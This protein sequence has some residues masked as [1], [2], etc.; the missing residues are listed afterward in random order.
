MNAVEPRPIYR[1]IVVQRKAQVDHIDVEKLRRLR[2]QM[3]AGQ[4]I[5]PDLQHLVVKDTLKKSV[6][7]AMAWSGHGDVEVQSS[8]TGLSPGAVFA[9]ADSREQRGDKDAGAIEY[10]RQEG[11]VVSTIIKDH[12]PGDPEGVYVPSNASYLF[13]PGFDSKPDAQGQYMRCAQELHAKFQAFS[14]NKFLLMAPELRAGLT[15]ITLV[16]TP[17][18]AVPRI[19]VGVELLME[20][21]QKTRFGHIDTDDFEV[22]SEI[23]EYPVQVPS[24]PDMAMMFVTK[25]EFLAAEAVR[26]GQ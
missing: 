24:D 20:F 7:M 9:E 14:D 11:V 15:L 5:D 23:G 6:K 21:H 10:Q 22:F 17:I 8:D 2:Q 12:M 16:M 19:D 18:I 26:R 4:D 13:H 25:G 3:D 1:H